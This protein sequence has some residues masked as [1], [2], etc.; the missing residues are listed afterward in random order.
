MML[1]DQATE[2]HTAVNR[3]PEP[4]SDSG[5]RT[6]RGRTAAEVIED[7]S[8]LERV[9]HEDSALSAVH[10]REGMTPSWRASIDAA[11]DAGT[12]EFEGHGG[13]EL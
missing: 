5:Y 13:I 3:H 4:P 11:T 9:G 1:E 6:S 2:E 8:R 7:V 12:M 10:V